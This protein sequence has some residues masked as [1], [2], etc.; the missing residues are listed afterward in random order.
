[1]AQCLDMKQIALALTFIALSSPLYADC[2]ADYK[3]KMDNPLRLHYGVIRLP[4][5]ACLRPAASAAIA[6]R[7]LSGGWQFLE[8]MSIFDESGLATRRNDA[9]QYYLRF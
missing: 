2:Y 6:Q 1:M 8:L 5:S 3:A 7:V 9:G 4:D